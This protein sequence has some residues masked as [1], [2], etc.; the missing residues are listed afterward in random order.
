M[1][2]PEIDAAY[3]GLWMR[4]NS[5]CHNAKLIVRPRHP[6]GY[7]SRPAENKTVQVKALIYLKDWKYRASSN[8]D[9]PVDILVQSVET[10][11]CDLNSMIKSTVQVMYFQIEGLNANP[12]LA[13]HYDF[14]HPIAEAHPVF[15]A[16]LGATKFEEN[17]I[18]AVDFRRQIQ[19]LEAPHCGN[20]KIPT[21]YMNLGSVLLGLAADHLP[22]RFFDEFLGELRKN[23]GTLW[24]ASCDGLQSSLRAR[25]GFLHSHHWYL[26]CAKQNTPERT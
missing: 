17:D 21:A 14:A 6:T 11:S 23:K 24:N 13:V 12:I 10:F 25:G 1:T 2:K 4:F 20:L 7:E 15:H 16:Q 26:H 3:T 8:R 9:K 22:R 18:K 19:P 5:V